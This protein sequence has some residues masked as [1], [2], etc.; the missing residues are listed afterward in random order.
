MTAVKN[1]TLHYTVM[2]SLGIHPVLLYSTPEPRTGL[3]L[4]CYYN[5]SVE[6][7]WRKQAHA[8]NIVVLKL[9]KT[10]VLDYIRFDFTHRKLI[11]LWE[12]VYTF[13]KANIS[14]G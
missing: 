7:I 4:I 12:E 8:W 13:S 2:E 3:D 14:I 11:F 5:I 10:S 1:F 9:I 6:C